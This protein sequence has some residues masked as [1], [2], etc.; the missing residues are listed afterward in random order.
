MRD[1]DR[2]LQKFN[3]KKKGGIMRKSVKPCF[4]ESSKYQTLTYP[5]SNPEV[6]SPEI[7]NQVIVNPENNASVYKIMCSH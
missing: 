5:Y 6:V 1:F 7:V 3:N 2:I 4:F